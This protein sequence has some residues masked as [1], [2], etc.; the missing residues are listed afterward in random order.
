M[1]RLRAIRKPL[2][3]QRYRLS[4]ALSRTFRRLHHRNISSRLFGWYSQRFTAM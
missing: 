2:A 3:L 1:N 4:A